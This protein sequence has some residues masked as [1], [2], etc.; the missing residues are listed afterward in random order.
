[1]NMVVEMRSRVRIRTNQ[2]DI[3]EGIEKLICSGRELIWFESKV[4]KM[5]KGDGK[6]DG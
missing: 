5:V 2:V 6:V 1:M 3:I 4:R